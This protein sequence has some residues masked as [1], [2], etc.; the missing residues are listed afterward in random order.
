MYI[1]YGSRSLQEMRAHDC[2][3]QP[4]AQPRLGQSSSRAQLGSTR[5]RPQAQQPLRVARA[6]RLFILVVHVC[7]IMC[8]ASGKVCVDQNGK[9]LG[10][11]EFYFLPMVK[12]WG[13]R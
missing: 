6:R 11:L 2:A 1:L 8:G 5:P 9:S 3:V 4:P 10:V 12:V 13:L 7:D